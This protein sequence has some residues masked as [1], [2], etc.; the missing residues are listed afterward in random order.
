VQPELFV[1]LV[2]RLDDAQRITLLEIF[3]SVNIQA[4]SGQAGEFYK[5]RMSKF[6]N[7]LGRLQSLG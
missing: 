1:P 4:I 3:R 2:G 7:Y 5:S 6:W